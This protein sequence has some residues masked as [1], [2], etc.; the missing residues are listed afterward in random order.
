MAVI[1]T[2]A[3]TH[4]PVYGEFYGLKEPPFDL[5][6]DPRFLF[7][8][9]Q[10]REA[11]AT[12]RLGL[13]TPRGFTVVIGDVGAGKTTL[14]HAAVAELNGL[15]HRCVLLTNPTLQRGEFYDFLARG[16]GL[17]NAARNSKTQF[18]VE[19]EPLLKQRSAGGGITTLM[20][21]EAQSLSHELLEEV[22]LLGNMETPGLKLLN[23]ILLGQ[24]EL[25]SRLEEPSWRQLKQRISLRCELANL[26]LNETA[27]YIAGRLRIAGGA[28]ADIFT[29]DA[30]IAVHA[31]AKGVPRT[32]NVL[33]DNT[34]IAGY[35][36]QVVPV[37]AAF[38]EEVSRD[39]KLSPTGT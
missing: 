29:R 11:Q 26:N 7:L 12:L 35:A 30:V 27:S 37:T 34:L 16:F 9:P 32:I 13:T 15:E 23:I 5:S 38:V 14:A 19:L 31:A 4:Q 22:R 18:F 2:L 28:A 3:S 8:T 6:P 20:V 36:A 21:D 24:S 39:F 25:G 1:D 33:C 17:S 10:H